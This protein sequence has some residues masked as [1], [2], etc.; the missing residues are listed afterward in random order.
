MVAVAV[1]TSRAVMVAII[2]LALVADPSI[3][4]LAI[5]WFGVVG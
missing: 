5:V 4:C 1:G 3:D 2:S